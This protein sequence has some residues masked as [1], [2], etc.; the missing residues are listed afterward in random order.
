[1]FSAIN[2]FVK[3]YSLINIQWKLL[4]TYRCNLYKPN[5]SMAQQLNLYTTPYRLPSD[6][7]KLEFSSSQIGIQ[8]EMMMP[9]TLY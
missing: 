6:S 8:R 4:F 1:M 7:T 2:F 9:I 3:I 5:Y